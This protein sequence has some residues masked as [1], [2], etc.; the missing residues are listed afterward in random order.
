[1]TISGTPS[2]DLD[3]VGVA[4]LVWRKASPHAGRASYAAQLRA[5]G[6]GRPRAS[7]RG[8]VDDAEQRSDRE[9]ARA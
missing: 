2:R 4:Q 9:L 8:A 5:R 3:G 1:M 6:G 7:A